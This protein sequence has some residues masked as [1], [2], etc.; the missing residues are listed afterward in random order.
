[1]FS[2]IKQVAV[3]VLSLA[4]TSK[5]YTPTLLLLLRSYIHFSSFIKS[6]G[7]RGENQ[8][9]NS[10]NTPPG[11]LGH[12]QASH[13]PLGQATNSGIYNRLSLPAK[14]PQIRH[15]GTGY[16]GIPWLCPYQ[17]IDPSRPSY[18]PEEFNMLQVLGHVMLVQP[19]DTTPF[20]LV[21]GEGDLASRTCRADCVEGGGSI[22]TIQQAAPLS[23]D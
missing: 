10:S 6:S 3:K 17:E 8:L 16:V 12:A 21:C 9:V 2:L 13:G 14:C 15:S 23:H 18:W 5:E 22:H 1:M 20:T 11:G 19:A 7:N 4:A